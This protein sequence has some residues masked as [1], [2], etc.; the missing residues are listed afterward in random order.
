MSFT[1]A[2][3]P[4]PG[5]TIGQF[6]SGADS[7][8][9]H[10][11]TM[12][13]SSSSNE[14]TQLSL[15]RGPQDFLPLMQ[16]RQHT[17]M[18]INPA[19]S[20][21][22]V[23]GQRNSKDLIILQSLPSKAEFYGVAHRASIDVMGQSRRQVRKTGIICTIGPKTNTP[24]ALAGLRAS[25]MNIM[26]MNFSHGSHEYH[27]GVIA[28]LR[29]SFDVLKDGPP[30]AI[31]LDTKGQILFFFFIP[32]QSRVHAHSQSLSSCCYDPL[33]SCCHVCFFFIFCFCQVPRSARAT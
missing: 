14:L 16:G 28:N 22:S 15:D 33:T 8:P 32:S 2:A 7:G 31:A 25:G 30:C 12:Q 20:P 10:F 9:E 26:R 19:A 29:K 17:P 5:A 24:E 21:M 27:A 18:S 4:V 3:S 11:G 23:P 6:P 13:K 1:P